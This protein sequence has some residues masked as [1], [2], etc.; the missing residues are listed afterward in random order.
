MESKAAPGNQ[1]IALRDPRGRNDPVL[2]CARSVCAVGEKVNTIKVFQVDDV[3]WMAGTDPESCA[4]EFLK[5]YGGQQECLDE[6][7]PPVEITP[8]QMARM[9]VKS[10]DGEP[11]QTFQEALNSMISSGMVFPTF[12][13]STEY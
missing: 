4:A 8:E 1:G 2:V 12:F 13:A 7:G 6:F 9:I 3:T 11:D 5:N 10:E